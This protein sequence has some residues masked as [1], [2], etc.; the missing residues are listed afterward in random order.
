M[1]GLI[2]LVFKAPVIKMMFFFLIFPCI[3][4]DMCVCAFGC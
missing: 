4:F 3:L 1:F 2:E